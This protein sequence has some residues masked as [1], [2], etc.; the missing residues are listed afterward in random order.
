[1][2]SIYDLYDLSQVYKI[3]RF[4]PDYELHCEVLLKVIGVLRNRQADHDKN[5]FRAALRQIPSLD[6]E[7]YYFV[8]VDNLYVYSPGDLCDEHVYEIL[9]KCCECLLGAVKE[10]NVEKIDALADC[11]HNLPK[12]IVENHFA[13]PK[14]FWRGEVKRYRKMWDKDF[15]R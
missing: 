15:L 3:I 12:D 1:M 9:I 6:M 2:L 7:K 13:I 8:S 10:R 5:Q 11:L 14:R 4:W